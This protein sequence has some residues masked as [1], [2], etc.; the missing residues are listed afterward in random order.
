M[1]HKMLLSNYKIIANAS[2]MPLDKIKISAILANTIVLYI[3]YLSPKEI[4]SSIIYTIA[5]AIR[6]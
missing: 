2:K 6:L 4:D 1:R 5:I 3:S